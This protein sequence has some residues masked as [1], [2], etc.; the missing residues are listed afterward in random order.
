MH[1][2]KAGLHCCCSAIRGSRIALSIRTSNTE[3]HADM[4]AHIHILTMCMEIDIHIP[5]TS[6]CCNVLNTNLKLARFRIAKHIA[7][8][9]PLLCLQPPHPKDIIPRRGLNYGC[10]GSELFWIEQMFE[11]KVERLL[12]YTRICPNGIRG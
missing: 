4:Y 2:K 8:L 5:R 7:L 3:A 9:T 11:E 1:T 6:K 10:K 12:Y